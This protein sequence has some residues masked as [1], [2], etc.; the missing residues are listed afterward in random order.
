MTGLTLR[1]FCADDA[2][3][4][5]ALQGRIYST[6]G[7][8]SDAEPGQLSRGARCPRVPPAANAQS[9]GKKAMVS[10]FTCAALQSGQYAAALADR[11]GK[12]RVGLIVEAFR[13]KNGSFRPAPA[14][15]LKPQL[16]AYGA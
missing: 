13:S 5:A 8:R 15:E 14:T 2:A 1:P 9:R 16:A 4:V 12:T 11:L 6:S 7:W 10:A 3:Q